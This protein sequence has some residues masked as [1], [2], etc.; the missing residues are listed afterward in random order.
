MEDGVQPDIIQNSKVVCHFSLSHSY[1]GTKKGTP[2]GSIVRMPLSQ[3]IMRLTHNSRRYDRDF[4]RLQSEAHFII[5]LH[6]SHHCL[7]YAD[8][9]S[10][11]PPRKVLWPKLSKLTEYGDMVVELQQSESL[12]QYLSWNFCL[13]SVKFQIKYACYWQ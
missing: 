2:K 6:F 7:F 8:S 9:F 10:M 5:S 3:R 12:G 11:A 1:R 4:A 13:N